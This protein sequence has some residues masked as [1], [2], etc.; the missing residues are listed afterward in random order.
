MAIDDAPF[1]VVV[2]GAGLAG[3]AAAV[4]LGRRGIRTVLIDPRATCAPCFKAEKIEPDQADLLRRLDLMAAVVPAATR[5][6]SI[7]SGYRG[8]VLSRT[9]VEQYGIAYPDFVN[10]IR[11]AGAPGV[12]TIVSRVRSVA[13]GPARQ[14]VTLD[15]GATVRARLIVLASGSSGAAV[16]ALGLSRV[17]LSQPHSLSFGFTI[18]PAGRET[19]PFDSLTYYAERADTHID[20]VTL[21]PMCGQMRVNLFTYWPPRDGRARELLGAPAGMLRLALPGLTRIAGDFR[22]TTPVEAGPVSLTAVDGHRRPGVV[23]IGDAFQTACPATGSGVSK[24]LTDVD[25]LRECVPDW[26]ATDGMDAGK[27]ARFY[28]A[29]RKIAAD[30]VSL[31]AARYRR[32]VSTEQSM[33]WRLHR[34]KVYF[35]QAVRGAWQ[36]LV[37]RAEPET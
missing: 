19:F 1:D 17:P 2:V 26:L 11:A 34:R 18:A 4:A 23:V 3:A 9:P 31:Q 37:D 29:P 15:S 28:D 27:I 33:R 8:R 25:I 32:R 14:T 7:T 10:Q 16:A 21:F 30:A 35:S 24:V 36:R 5:I 22:V 20:Y 13:T 6:H 12:R